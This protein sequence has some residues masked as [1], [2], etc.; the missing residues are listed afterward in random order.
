MEF[1]RSMEMDAESDAVGAV[2]APSPLEVSEVSVGL[3]GLVLSEGFDLLLALLL[4]IPS[5]LVVILFRSLRL[6]SGGRFGF[7]SL[8]PLERDG[9]LG[10]AF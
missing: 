1:S 3:V 8:F 7:G 4:L 10:V 6:K 9:R 5:L 2:C